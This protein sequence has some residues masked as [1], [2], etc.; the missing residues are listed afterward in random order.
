MG[1]EPIMSWRNIKIVQLIDTLFMF[2]F[3]NMFIF[4]RNEMG[5]QYVDACLSH[6]ID[7]QSIR[8]SEVCILQIS[9]NLDQ[10]QL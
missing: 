3:E 8:L 2:N 1:C 7:V 6:I 9:I 5:F 10:L 4:T